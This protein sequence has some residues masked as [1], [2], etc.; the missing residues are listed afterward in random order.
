MKDK[1]MY[2]VLRAQDGSMLGAR[3]VTA[4]ETCN[5]RATV[6][7]VFIAAW[8]GEWTS[9]P[10]AEGQGSRREV[11]NRDAVPL[12]SS[13]PRP[14]TRAADSEDRTRLPLREQ[15]DMGKA[16]DAKTPDVKASPTKASAAPP[17][18]PADA[19]PSAT[20]ASVAPPAAAA[21]TKPVAVAAQ[22]PRGEV[23]GLGFGTHDGDAGSFGAGLLVG[24]GP[25]GTLNLAALFEVT[26]ERE[27]RLGPGLAGYRTLR[28]GFG[29][30]LLRKR[31][32][33]FGDVG[34]FPELTLLTLNGK[35]LATGRSA[36]TWGPAADL[37]ARLGLAWGRVAPFLFAGASYAL[38]GEHITLDDRPETI[39]LS[40]W[41]VSAG[42]GLAFLLGAR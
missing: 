30:G 6:A 11:P 21:Q 13:I 42:G 34:I 23:A 27:R 5:Q 1:W 39:T 19:A 41:N 28:L 32:R 4:P 33:M 40:R 15:R 17:A 2:V 38:R 18:V 7:A 24:Y 26:G 22:G 35:Q 14:G 31:G 20:K 10:L 16:D 25:T 29:A 9:A 36:T 37:R 12:S 3:Q 8:V